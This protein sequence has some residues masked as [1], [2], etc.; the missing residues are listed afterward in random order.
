MQAADEYPHIVRKA[1]IKAAEWTFSHPWNPKSAITGSHLSRLGGL[2]RTGVSIAR[3][4]PGKESFAYHLHHA[5]EEWI[6]VLSGKAVAQIDGT[7]YVLEAGDFAAFPTPSVAHNMANPGPREL[8]Y[9]MGGENNPHEVSDFP[10]LDKRMVKLHGK[11]EIYKL[12]DGKA[13]EGE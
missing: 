10:T 8:V 12:S 9:L 6:Y 1:A 4:A 5:E 7:E 11:V 2:K 3:L 13:L